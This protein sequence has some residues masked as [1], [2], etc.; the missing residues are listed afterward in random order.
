M[1]AENPYDAPTNSESSSDF[2]PKLL[3]LVASHLLTARQNPP[4]IISTL[5]RWPGTPSFLL[6]GILGTAV[7]AFMSSLPH[8]ELTSHWPIGY[9]CFVLGGLLR[10]FGLARRVKRLWKPQSHF[11]DWQKV[12]EFSK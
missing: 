6:V 4:T 9:A 3:R 10:D 5:S 1:N 7:L 8:S 12:D 2:D 11:I